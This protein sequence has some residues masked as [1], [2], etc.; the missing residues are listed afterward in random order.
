VVTLTITIRTYPRV[1]RYGPSHFLDF[2]ESPRF[3]PDVGLNT[4]ENHYWR[5][6]VAMRKLRWTVGAPRKESFCVPKE[7]FLCIAAPAPPATST[8]IGLVVRRWDTHLLRQRH[9]IFHITISRRR[10]SDAHTTTSE[11]R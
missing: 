4:H 10:D 9:R 3:K 6:I 5:S 1:E 11:P 7:G 8:S 2:G